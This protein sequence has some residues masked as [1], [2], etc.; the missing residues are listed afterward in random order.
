MTL[1]LSLALSSMFVLSVTVFLA[2]RA[3]A[4]PE[5]MTVVAKSLAEH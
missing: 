2:P 3:E 4:V 5:A 1:R